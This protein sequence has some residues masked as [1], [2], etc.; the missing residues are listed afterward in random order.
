MGRKK[1]K[2]PVALVTGGSRGIGQGIC[3]ELARHGYAVAI[4][5]AGNEEAARHTQ[6]LI[7]GP[8]ATLLCRADVGVTAEREHSRRRARRWRSRPPRL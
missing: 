8:S 4:N 5:Y 1:S 3:L 2:N 7:E 6:S